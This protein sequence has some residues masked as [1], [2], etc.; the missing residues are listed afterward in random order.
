MSKDKSLKKQRQALCE[1]LLEAQ[2]ELQQA[3]LGPVL[4]LVSGNDLAGKAEL[5]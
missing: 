4:L 3:N 2:F 5:I 1:D